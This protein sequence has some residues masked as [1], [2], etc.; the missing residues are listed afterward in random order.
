MLLLVH[1]NKTDFRG[2]M[3]TGTH[4]TTVSARV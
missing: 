4:R 3:N 1:K 2:S